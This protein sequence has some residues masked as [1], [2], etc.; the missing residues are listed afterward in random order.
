MAK[1]K[2]CS[3]CKEQKPTNQFYK[4]NKCKDKLQYVCKDCSNERVTKL[5]KAD[6]SAIIYRI[7][8]PLG[9]V[10][11]G[12]TK[13]SPIARW[14]D[15]KSRYKF[16]KTEGKS[17]FP[18]LHK[19]FD[20]YGIDNHIFEVVVDLGNISKEDLKLAEKTHIGLI[21]KKGNSLNKYN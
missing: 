5:L 13:K 3:C 2:K 1:M 19:S 8:N 17:T 11:I 12:K 7:V 10:Y 14:T 6:K 4:C 20:K 16:Q 9:E 21:K 15:H 18:L